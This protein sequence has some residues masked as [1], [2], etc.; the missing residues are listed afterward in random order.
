[1]IADSYFEIGN[2]HEVC[3]D[4]ALSG[5]L[6]DNLS[7]AIITD[8]CSQSHKECG[9]VDLGA[10]VVAYAARDALFQ[11]FNKETELIDNRGNGSHFASMRGTISQ[12]VL[13]KIKDIRY[14]LQLNEIYSDSTLIVAISDSKL[15][16]VFMFGDGGVI[17]KTKGDEIIYDEVSYLSSAPYYISYDNKERENLYIKE[18]GNSPV[19]HSRYMIPFNGDI[20]SVKVSHNQA[21]EINYSIYDF[22][23]FIYNDFSSISITSDGI[24]SFQSLESENKEVEAIKMAKRFV[25]FKSK[26]Q[27]FLKRRMLMIKKENANSK[28]THYDDISVASILV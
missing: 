1:M 22:S 23:S 13:R 2:T 21:K 3:Q 25:D 11:F 12:H 4:Y 18:F 14:S 6:N 26:S 27:V 8:G 15:A 20:E 28:I 19:I 7:Y 5:K 16:Y 9:E 17:I 10:R 24:K